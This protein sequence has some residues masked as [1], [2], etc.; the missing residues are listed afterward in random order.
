MGR[1]QS[2]WPLQ[3][4]KRESDW[5]TWG[6]SPGSPA[7]RLSSRAPGAEA[8]PSHRRLPGPPL[9]GPSRSSFSEATLGLLPRP[10]WAPPARGAA[11]VLACCP[12]RG[13]S[14]PASCISEAARGFPDSVVGGDLAENWLPASRVSWVSYVAMQLYF[15]PAGA[16]GLL[17]ALP[18]IEGVD[19]SLCWRPG[20]EGRAGL[21]AH[22]FVTLD[23]SLHF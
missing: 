13:A 12:P 21:W 22:S 2:S 23:N 20:A 8:Q 14:C 17:Q 10:A 9:E 7:R 4:L 16:P 3:A 11:K 19:G 6:A 5:G 15:L 18:Q 1:I